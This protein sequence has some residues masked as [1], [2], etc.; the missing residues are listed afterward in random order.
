MCRVCAIAPVIGRVRIVSV[1]CRNYR[2]AHIPIRRGATAIRSADTRV[3]LRNE[4]T[5]K[6]SLVVP[7]RPTC[8]Y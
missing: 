3:N 1:I 2:V 5:P 4:D 6:H 7:K 8:A